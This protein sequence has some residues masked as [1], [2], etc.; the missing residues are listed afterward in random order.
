MLQQNH[1]KNEYT[2][3]YGT[4]LSSRVRRNK[5][6]IYM[7]IG[8]VLFAAI[9]II[10]TVFAI[11]YRNNLDENR[12]QKLNIEKIKQ[13]MEQM[14]LDGLSARYKQNDIDTIYS[15]EHIGQRRENSINQDEIST[16]L[17]IKYM[18]I[19]GLKNKDIENKINSRISG[20][21]VKLYTNEEVNNPDIDYISIS[22]N[23]TANFSN[24]I[25]VHLIK[26][27]KKIND[28]REE[29]QWRNLNIDL[30]TGDDISFE[31]LFLPG[32]S[33]KSILTQV[34]YDN[35]IEQCTEHGIIVNNKVDVG[36]IEN[37]V[38]QL[39]NKYKPG[40]ITDFYYDSNTV[41][42]AIDQTWYS[43]QMW[44]YYDKIS[45]YKRFITSS[46]I[47]DETHKKT[48]ENFVFQEI[49]EE[50]VNQEISDNFVAIIITPYNL[51]NQSEAFI[52]KFNE[53]F[54]EIKVR[55]QALKQE[56]QSNK[57]QTIIFASKINLNN[58]K[59]YWSYTPEGQNEAKKSDFLDNFEI[60]DVSEN[61]RIIRIAND[62][63]VTALIQEMY[64]RGYSLEKFTNISQEELFSLVGTKAKIESAGKDSSIVELKSNKAIE[65]AIE[66]QFKIKADEIDTLLKNVNLQEQDVNQIEYKISIL[67]GNIE[68]LEGKFLNQNNAKINNIVQTNK[69]R[70]TE[71]EHAI[72]NNRLKRE[73]QGVFE[74]QIK[75]LNSMKQESNVTIVEEKAYYLSQIINTY[76]QKNTYNSSEINTLLSSYSKE[77]VNIQDWTINIR[78]KQAEEARKRLE[79][80]ER[81]KQNLINNNT[82][83]NN[84]NSTNNTTNSN[85][86]NT[87]NTTNITNTT[88]TT[89]TTNIRNNTTSNSINYTNNTTTTNTTN[90]IQNSIDSFNI[91]VNSVF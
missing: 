42:F 58:I 19:K 52:N 83:S 61:E 11:M 29:K 85:S 66:D 15:I 8:C 47:F 20:E 56:A 33:I 71:F 57:S 84:T 26:T 59:D 48:Q 13:T 68:I 81:K 2:T 34:I 73:I 87:T 78:Q 22:S 89:N 38:Y 16:K 50:L 10:I 27:V 88:N 25:S 7:T 37:E 41:C 49:R 32:I 40:K 24:T 67:K 70:I 75:D 21:M 79:E 5:G 28:T 39:V 62:Y 31:D 36:E 63:F 44:K 4:S 30:N 6:M 77:I 18:A 86:L 80:E 3:Y 72:Y 90:T 12:L 23:V 54:N 82:I 74:N 9:C 76:A 17:T 35:L 69:Q 60:C 51:K 43:F 64:K 65:D 1:K 53:Y 91:V 45:I 55:V 46:N 14:K